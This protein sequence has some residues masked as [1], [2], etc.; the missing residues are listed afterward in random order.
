[1]RSRN[2]GAWMPSARCLEDDFRDPLLFIDPTLPTW[3]NL[4]NSGKPASEIGFDGVPG[5][6]FDRF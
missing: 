3:P 5:M 2:T 4:V 6:I 1:M